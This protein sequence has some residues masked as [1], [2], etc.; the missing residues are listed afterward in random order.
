[1]KCHSSR[2]STVQT[3]GGLL[4]EP[5]AQIQNTE[6]KRDRGSG[7]RGASC[8]SRRW[9]TLG[10]ATA[11]TRM[12]SRIWII[13]AIQGQNLFCRV[14]Y[15][16]HVYHLRRLK[17]ENPTEWQPLILPQEVTQV[18][19]IWTERRLNWVLWVDSS[20]QQWSYDIYGTWSLLYE[21][22][23]GKEY[24]NGAPLKILTKLCIHYNTHHQE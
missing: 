20:G 8:N 13:I 16:K 15:L 1:M 14:N 2:S 18:S 22:W 3:T 24:I 19:L 17:Q 12:R 6:R 9:E 7:K 21:K 5:V 10:Q 11:A 23:R 4:V